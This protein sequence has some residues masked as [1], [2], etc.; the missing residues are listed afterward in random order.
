VKLLKR[1]P[2]W[3]LIA[4]PILAM[5]LGAA[6]NQVVLIANDGRFPVQLNAASVERY[7]DNS[8][9]VNSIV[10]LDHIHTV[11]RPE[12]HLKLM[13]DVI[14]IGPIE[15]IGDLFLDLGFWSFQFTPLMWLTLALRNLIGQS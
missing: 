7:S 9:T 8:K 14:N 11:M 4:L 15:S 3:Q 5:F 12:D 2:Y 10:Y 13:A 6:S 1:I